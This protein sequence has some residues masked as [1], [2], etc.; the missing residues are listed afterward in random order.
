MLHWSESVQLDFAV[1]IICV[2]SECTHKTFY[3]HKQIYNNGVLAW[4]VCSLWK[5]KVNVHEYWVYT[6]L[7]EHR[8][9]LLFHRRNQRIVNSRDTGILSG[10]TCSLTP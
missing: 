7:G 5:Y 6:F 9:I 3:K 1:F 10:N 2:D 8:K 4:R